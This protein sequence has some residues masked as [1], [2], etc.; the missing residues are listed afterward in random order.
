MSRMSGSPHRVIP[1]KLGAS[2]V[3]GPVQVGAPMRSSVTNGGQ[4]ALKDL[5][6]SG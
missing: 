5:L 3:S 2:P 1:L 6:H 4:T